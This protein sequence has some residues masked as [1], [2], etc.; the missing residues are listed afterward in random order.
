MDPQWDPEE[1]WNLDIPSIM[2]YL[3]VFFFN[4]KEFLAIT[5]S[6]DLRVSMEKTCSASNTIVI[7]QGT[8]GST[9]YNRQ[10]GFIHNKG[11]LNPKIADAIGAGDSFNAGFIYKFINGAGL[12]ECQDFGSLAGAVSTTK[13][14]G[15][16]SFDDPK[17]VLKTMMAFRKKN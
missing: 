15:T 12:A 6:S 17:E 10:S 5:K 7:K 11:Y 3:D 1:K 13:T 9:L 16:A 14:G 8:R 2:E 4:E